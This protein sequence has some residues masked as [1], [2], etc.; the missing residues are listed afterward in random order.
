[1]PAELL[2]GD[3]LEAMQEFANSLDQWAHPKPKGMPDQGRTPT[4]TPAGASE[5][6]WA[7]SLFS[8]L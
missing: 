2:H 8:D 4:G 5:R 7:N 1:M 6:A 3:T